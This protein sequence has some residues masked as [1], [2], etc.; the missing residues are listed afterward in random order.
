MKNDSKAADNASRYELQ[1]FGN[2][3][4]K[5]GSLCVLAE[6]TYKKVVADGNKDENIVFDSIRNLAEVEF[7]RFTFREFYLIAVDC[8]ESD[9]WKRIKSSGKGKA[10]SYDEFKKVDNRD[11]NQ[12]DIIYGQQV[13]MCVDEADYL[14]RNDNERKGSKINITE[15]LQGKLKDPI[16]LFQKEKLRPPGE[17]EAYMSIA[18]AASL[19]SNCFKR[20]VGAVIIDKNQAV[21][22]MGYNENSEPLKPCYE[23]F[24]NCFREKYIEEVMSKFRACPLC[25]EKLETTL[26]FPYRC[27]HCG[28]NVYREIIK[29]R[30]MGRCTALH[31][32]E[33]ALLSAERADL[34]DCTL[35]VTTFPCFTCTEKILNSRMVNFCYVESYPDLDA[36]RLLEEARREGRK[37][38]MDKFE[39]VKAK[40][41]FKL[42]GT[43]R[44]EK[45]TEMINLKKQQQA[46][47]PLP[48]GRQIKQKTVKTKRIKKEE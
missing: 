25:A 3:L 6:E 41:Y 36:L 1:E 19:R 34:S 30:A 2:E 10:L 29:D 17:K 14:I 46:C 42:F 11:K 27:P 23:L 5:T 48:R 47:P 8:T 20:Q 18:Y 40:A 22:S 16:S 38:L 44:R 39:G 43:W 9:R 4:R 28:E 35:Y 21:V 13:S 45:E 33:K 32:E 31:A 15:K 37:I 12:D 7:L 26:V 24:K